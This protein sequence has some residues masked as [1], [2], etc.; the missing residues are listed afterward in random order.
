MLLTIIRCLSRCTAWLI[1][2]WLRSN[3]TALLHFAAMRGTCVCFWLRSQGQIAAQ[4]L[5]VIPSSAQRVL[6]ST[7]RGRH[8]FPRKRAIHG[9]SGRGGGQRGQR[10][11]TYTLCLWSARCKERFKVRWKKSQEGR[12]RRGNKSLQ[13]RADGARLPQVTT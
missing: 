8:A 4:L 13:S 6:H 10:W 2:C 1:F 5:R 12:A 3:C 7:Q 11:F 9:L